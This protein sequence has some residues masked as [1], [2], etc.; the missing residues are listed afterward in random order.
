MTKRGVDKILPVFQC[1]ELFFILGKTLIADR[2]KVEV[3]MSKKI[4]VTAGIFL[5]ALSAA[6]MIIWENGGRAA[7]FNDDV[8][9]T[10]RPI[11][12]GEILAPEDLKSLSLA[13]EGI[14]AD[15]I[16]PENAEKYIGKTLKY[17][18]N[19]NSQIAVNS[20]I[21][22]DNKLE[23][24]MTIFH[25]KSSWIKNLSSSVRSADRVSIYAYT[26]A[27]GAVS[28]GTYYTAFVK[29]GNGREVIESTGFSEPRILKRTSGLYVPVEIEIA[30]KLSD[31]IR[32]VSYV[33]QGYT[34]IIM[35]EGVSIY[36]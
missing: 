25:I 8:L 27:S 2:Q 28:V 32:I 17:D 12:A 21:S 24:G 5:I 13:Q 23:D 30:A 36:E 31:Y 3:I 11:H 14:M 33:E 22:G 7:V 34:L 6:L 26:P 16:T 9:V 15:C 1:Q 35:Q 19:E 10:T 29:D 4:K 20:F 18:I